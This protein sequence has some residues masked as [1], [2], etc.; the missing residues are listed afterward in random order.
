MKSVL[1]L[2]FRLVTKMPTQPMPAFGQGIDQGIDGCGLGAFEHGAVEDDGRVMLLAGGAAV[3]AVA[4][5]RF[6]GCGNF[7][8]FQQVL[9][10]AE[11]FRGVELAAGHQIL[12]QALAILQ[13][14]GSSAR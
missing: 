9:A 10:I 6:G 7:G 13:A 8:V 12:A 11:K 5:R 4:W 14:A 3:N 1:A 2:S